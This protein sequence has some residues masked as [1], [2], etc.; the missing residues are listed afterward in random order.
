MTEKKPLIKFV[1]VVSYC[2]LTTVCKYTKRYVVALYGAHTVE[3]QVEQQLTLF[4]RN[5]TFYFLY[6]NR[7]IVTR[8]SKYYQ[9]PPSPHHYQPLQQQ[10]QRQ[11]QRQLPEEEPKRRSSYGCKS[12]S[13]NPKPNTVAG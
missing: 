6:N 1:K 13:S 7:K 8:S 5:S 2:D 3:F 10:S 4:L 12:I 11:P 9:P